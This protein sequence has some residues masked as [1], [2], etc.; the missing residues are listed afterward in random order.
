MKQFCLTSLIYHTLKTL[1]FFLCFVSSCQL[2]ITH[3]W[4]S[5]CIQQNVWGNCIRNVIL[6][7]QL[8]MYALVSNFSFD[9]CL[10][11]LLQLHQRNTPAVT[12]VQQ[13]GLL[14][15]M[16]TNVSLIYKAFFN[17]LLVGQN[18]DNSCT[19]GSLINQP[20]S[21]QPCNCRWS[22]D[23]KELNKKRKCSNDPYSPYSQDCKEVL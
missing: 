6:Y 11:S 17:G 14:I 12:T 10:Y 21:V 9:S 13:V 15:I 2:H 23:W 19:F 5:A 4:Q 3:Q 1:F 16:I 18:G 8:I 7:V 20:A 22:N